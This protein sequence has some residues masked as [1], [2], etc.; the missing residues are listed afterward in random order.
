MPDK[1]ETI[2]VQVGET[3]NQYARGTRTVFATDAL[4]FPISCT[5]QGRDSF[6][7]TYGKQTT[8]KLNYAAA[9]R[10]LGIVLFHA[11]ACDG[12][13]DNECGRGKLE[14]VEKYYAPD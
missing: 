13:L 9:C 2:A 4:A 1:V 7:V 14:S 5:Q 11:L 3:D 8:A 12:R 10:E 6:T